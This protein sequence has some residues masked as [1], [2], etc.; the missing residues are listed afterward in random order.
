[1]GIYT[2]LFVE[3][4]KRIPFERLLFSAPDHTKSLE[5]FAQREHQ[6]TEAIEKLEGKPTEAEVRAKI[7]A[8]YQQ[9]DELKGLVERG[10][11]SEE[12]LARIV[13]KEKARESAVDDT[14]H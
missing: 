11:L 1:M 9:A 8:V 10:L 6:L 5:R 7:R 2:Q 13:E 14:S 4:I 12:L 3:A